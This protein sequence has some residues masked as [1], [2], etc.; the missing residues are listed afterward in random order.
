MSK[1]VSFRNLKAKPILKTIGEVEIYNINHADNLDRKKQVYEYTTSI[2]K[3]LAESEV[4]EI[5]DIMLI[6]KD[7]LLSI[8]PMISNINFDGIEDNELDEILNS[9]G[10]VLME[11]Q[12]TVNVIMNEIF[13]QLMSIIEDQGE[14]NPK[15]GI[16]NKW[17]AK[18]EAKKKQL[19]IDEARKVLAELEEGSVYQ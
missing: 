4:G 13:V 2:I 14:N 1:M 15:Q 11:V 19:K 16:L 8:I 3:T 7:V 5:E 18:E 6:G 10:E 17:A 9:P 12:S